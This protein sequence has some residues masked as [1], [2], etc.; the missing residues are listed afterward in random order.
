M[1]ENRVQE[2]RLESGMTQAE[3]ASALEVTRQ[4]IISLEKNRYI[5]SLEMG[6]KVAA[7]FSLPIE[8]VF[9]YRAE[10]ASR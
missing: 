8:K 7:V 3:L 2:L 4:T 6:F 9:I 1:I 5:P 10:G